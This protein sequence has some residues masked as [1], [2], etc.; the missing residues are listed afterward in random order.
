M[1]ERMLLGFY[2]DDF[3]GSTDAMEV[4]ARSGYKTILFL[5]APDD[6]VIVDKF[7][8]YNCVGIAGVSRALPTNQLEDELETVFRTLFSYKPMFIH[9]KVCSTF[10]S[11]PQVGSI[12]K[13]PEIAR[14]HMSNQR[15]IPMLVASPALKR[16][17]V[18]GHHFASVAG[19]VYRLDRH[20]VMSKH[21]VTPM[22]E[23]D[24]RIH[25]AKQADCVTELLHVIDLDAGY[26]SVRKT[27]NEKLE[28][29]PDVILMDC[30]TEM[31]IEEI[32]RLLWEEAHLQDDPLFIIGSS[33]VEN[34][35]TNGWDRFGSKR[36][37]GEAVF[38]SPGEADAL[39]VVSGSCSPVTNQQVDHVL[40]AGYHGIH[41]QVHEMVQAEDEEL[42]DE[43]VKEACTCLQN[44]KSVVIYTAR[45]PEDPSIAEVRQSGL[46]AGES[47][48][49]LL[50]RI[51]KKIVR[52]SGIRRVCVA[53][54][55]TSGFA[56]RELG[57][58]ALEVLYP[59]APGAPLCICH[60][61][62][63]EMNGL[64]LALK[65]GQLGQI[66]YFEKVRKGV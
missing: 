30:L 33:G 60:S 51:T 62:E 20:P 40:Q 13:V 23:S 21:P 5:E 6:A 27:Y 55:D 53:G 2:G 42:L 17:T 41:L 61:D 58:Y 54:G 45:G 10:D 1:R 56:T 32:G 14:K 64:Q 8:G 35:L 52:S 66:D 44:G 25:L 24:L 12:G 57:V 16:Y 43:I 34:A 28:A 59:S 63:L 19:K 9:Y 49:R 50:G 38:Q 18:F 36:D 31:H 26:E 7:S 46:G 15:T 47:L 3:T 65:G 37:K 29:H 48:G 11:S 4:L 22:D 39:L